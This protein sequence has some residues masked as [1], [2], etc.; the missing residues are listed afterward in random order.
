MAG[1]VSD[2]PLRVLPQRPRRAWVRGNVSRPSWASWSGHGARSQPA[3]HGPEYCQGNPDARPS[4]MIGP[5][6]RIVS[7]RTTPTFPRREAVR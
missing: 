5:S 3:V 7:S 4:S 6:C 1:D 2:W